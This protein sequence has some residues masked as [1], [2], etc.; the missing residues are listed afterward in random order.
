MCIVL[1][2]TCQ[3]SIVS[4]VC[5]VIMI[6]TAAVSNATVS[7]TIMTMKVM[8]TMIMMVNCCQYYLFATVIA[9]DVIDCYCIVVLAIIKAAVGLSATIC[10]AAIIMITK[11]GTDFWCRFCKRICSLLKSSHKLPRR[12]SREQSSEIP[13][14][15]SWMR[16]MTRG[17]LSD[18]AA[19][20][21]HTFTLH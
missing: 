10:R 20:C 16:R 18:F 3:A 4:I 15:S 7:A 9:V 5:I 13:R 8:M 21:L 12:P 14:C 6:V 2:N 1:A 19:S 11:M 17:T